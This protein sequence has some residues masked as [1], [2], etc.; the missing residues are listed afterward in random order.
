[1]FTLKIVDEFG[2]TFVESFGSEVDARARFAEWVSFNE[3]GET[4]LIELEL[5]E[6]GVVLTSCVFE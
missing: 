6:S 5:S 3:S 4:P 2:V 1:M